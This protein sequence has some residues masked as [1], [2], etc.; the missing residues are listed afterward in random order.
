LIKQIHDCSFNEDT[1][2][3][4][5]KIKNPHFAKLQ[6]YFYADMNYSMR[7]DCKCAQLATSSHSNLIRLLIE[8]NEIDQQVKA[9]LARILNTI[10]RNYDDNL[11][12]FPNYLRL[13]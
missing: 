8:P 5:T 10:L 2:A 11:H 9:G 7:F 4:L 6:L 1:L 13:Y 12:E 3:V